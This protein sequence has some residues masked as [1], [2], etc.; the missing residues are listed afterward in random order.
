VLLRLVEE[1]KRSLHCTAWS[2]KR[3]AG[4]SRPVLN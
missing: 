2:G 3:R 1:R 4:A